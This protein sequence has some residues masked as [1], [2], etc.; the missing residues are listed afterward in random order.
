[1]AGNFDQLHPFFMNYAENYSLM[2]ANEEKGNYH[3]VPEIGWSDNWATIVFNY[4]H[5]DAVWREIFGDQRFR[6]AL[7]YAIN[8]QEINDALFLGVAGTPSSPAPPDG[9]PY[10]GEGEGFM[11]YSAFDPDKANQLLDE[12]GLKWNADHTVRLRPDGKPL[13]AVLTVLS[14]GPGK[15]VEITELYKTYFAAIGFNISIKPIDSSLFSQVLQS[16]E[17]DLGAVAVNWGG[18]RPII[19]GLYPDPLPLDGGW[20]V[21][22]KW[23]LWITSGGAS[24]DEPP[25]AVKQLYALHEAF[26]AEPDAQKRIAIENEIFKIHNDNFWII[27]S[28]KKQADS[29]QDYYHLISNRLINVPIPVPPETPYMAPSTWAI[30][31]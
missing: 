17:Y 28:V 7:S 23:G 4:S 8:R 26:V 2:K 15:P 13:E 21:N 29:I 22:P 5:K 31:K 11:K 20:V 25:E 18:R 19:T 1:L 30:K 9:P 24:G 3:L 10:F 14:T 12:M 6:I 27:A 16:G